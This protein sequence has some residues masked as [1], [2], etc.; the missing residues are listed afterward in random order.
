M[1]FKVGKNLV[2]ALLFLAGASG[3]RADVIGAA[4]ADGNSQYASFGALMTDSR[5]A[6]LMLGE[7]SFLDGGSIMTAYLNVSGGGFFGMANPWGAMP[8]WSTDFGDI[9]ALAGM[10]AFGADPQAIEAAAPALPLLPEPAPGAPPLP[11]AAPA[12][13]APDTVSPAGLGGEQPAAETAA[14]V[15]Y[16]APPPVP[17]PD[18]LSLAPAFEPLPVADTSAPAVAVPEPASLA[19]FALGLAGLLGARR[20]QS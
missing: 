19:L 6:A 16:S 8:S 17:M 9:G 4:G 13:P 7:G 10:P 5:N 1:Q 14:P 11:Q 2:L 15:L 12:A 3:A 18:E 20:R